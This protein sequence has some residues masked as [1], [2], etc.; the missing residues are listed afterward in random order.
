MADFVEVVDAGKGWTQVRDAEGNV[1]KLEGARNWRNN[2]PG[3]IEYGPFAQSLGAVGSDGRFAVFP[4]YEAG[5]QAKEQLIFSSPSYRDL[6]LEQAISRY[7]PPNEN[8]T[9]SYIN[10]V[11]AAAGVPASTPMSQIPQSVR[12]N[13]L[14]AMERVE[15]FKP[16]RTYNAQGIPLPPGEIP[17]MVATLQDTTPPPRVAPN[18]ATISP[19]LSLMRNPQMSSSARMAQVTPPL[20][21]PRP[22]SPMD[23]ARAPGTTVATIPTAIRPGQ[24]QIERITPMPSARE[25][26]MAPGTT[27]A[28]IPTT[29]RA[30]LPTLPHTI[31]GQSQI[32]RPMPSAREIASAPGTT[33]ATIPTSGIG[34]PPATRT[35]PSVPYTLQPTAREI[36]QAPGVTVAA[37]PTTQRPNAAQINDAA[38]RAALTANQGNVERAIPTRAMVPT[39]PQP[40]NMGSRDSVANA[41]LGQRVAQQIAPAFSPLDPFER[42]APNPIVQPS[43]VPLNQ[44]PIQVVPSP[45]SSI[46]PLPRRRPMT[47]ISPVQRTAQPMPRMAAPASPLRIVVN[48]GN[49]IQ[50]QRTTVQSLQS[51]GLSPSDAYALANAQAAQRARD[52]AT[53]PS[54]V[55]SNSWFNEVTG[56][57]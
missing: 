26:A 2:N 22:V 27:I 19:D 5:R 16:G 1:Y 39:A 12:G 21:Q 23:I 47:P 44:P 7:A 13:V 56:R 33:I 45:L 34:Q 14:N 43:F 53:S 38:R 31:P 15:G 3:N 10:Q 42:L 20:P 52:S 8:N 29:P 17:N 32:E 35:V 49:M 9:R 4:S 11:A 40:M 51:S 36:A 28:T 48:G 57:A 24:S 30:S 54:H 6:T 18:P 37:I 50:P 41:A 25:I 55:S 46:V